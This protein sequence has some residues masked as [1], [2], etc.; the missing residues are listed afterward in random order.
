LSANETTL[1]VPVYFGAEP[2]YL[3]RG[4]SA[5]ISAMECVFDLVDN[6]IDAARNQLLAGAG[7]K[8]D[9]RGLPTSY[10]GFHIDVSLDGSEVRVRLAAGQSQEE[11]AGEAGIGMRHLGRIERGEISPTIDTLAKVAA[12]LGV[13]PSALLLDPAE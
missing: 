1:S 7:I 5:D 3:I 4:L 2:A 11:L 13:H 12:V 6:A 9:S 10:A 8:K